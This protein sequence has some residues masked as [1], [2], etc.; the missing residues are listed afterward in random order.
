MILV[1]DLKLKLL[2]QIDHKVTFTIFHYETMQESQKNTLEYFKIFFYSLSHAGK[3]QTKKYNWI[4]RIDENQSMVVPYSGYW[5]MALLVTAYIGH[6]TKLL[7][8]N[9]M[10]L[11]N[12]SKVW[13]HIKCV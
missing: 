7:T 8:S 4:C 11:Q 6:L 5:S 10:H 13:W 12:L 2:E 3:K 9:S 1:R